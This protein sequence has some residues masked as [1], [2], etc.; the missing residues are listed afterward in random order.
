LT[1][2]GQMSSLRLFGKVVGLCGCDL[3]ES[4]GIVLVT[5]KC[6]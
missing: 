2:A 1:G 3:V 4:L 6:A 5:G